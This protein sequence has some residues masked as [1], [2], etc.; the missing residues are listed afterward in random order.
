MPSICWTV[1]NH[2]VA[3]VGQAVA[4][5]GHAARHII[6]LVTHHAVHQAASAAGPTRSWGQLV[7]K[8]IPATMLG[9]AVLVP[10]PLNPT[11]L[12]TAPVPIVESAPPVTPWL[13]PTG[14]P[15]APIAPSIVGQVPP[16]NAI[17]EPFSSGLLLGGVVWLLLIRSASR[18]IRPGASGP[19][20]GGEP[21]SR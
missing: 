17:P 8:F 5:V 1:I 18:R 13:F 3:P 12:P 21:R 16:V 6:H 7:C 9:S 20:L 14:S 15:G 19:L 4:H 2:A 10:H 11:L